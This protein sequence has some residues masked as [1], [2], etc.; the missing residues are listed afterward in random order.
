MSRRTNLDWV[1]EEYY[2]NKVYVLQEEWNEHWDKFAELP[3]IPRSDS[4][5]FLESD[6]SERKRIYTRA[7]NAL[8]EQC[9]TIGIEP[10]D[11]L[12]LDED[13]WTIEMFS[14]HPL[15]SVGEERTPEELLERWRV[16]DARRGTGLCLDGD[17]PSLS[18]VHLIY[19]I[20]RHGDL[21]YYDPNS[22]LHDMGLDYAVAT[23]DYVYSLHMPVALGTKLYG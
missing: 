6:W 21:L 3:S 13:F 10:A 14:Y 1:T 5:A 15:Y 16:Q 11:Y 9:I 12:R 20:L 19:D 22:F 2:W 18:G 17:I 23:M 8:H 7:S 4:R